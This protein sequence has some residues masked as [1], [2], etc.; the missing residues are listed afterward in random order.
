MVQ[1]NLSPHNNESPTRS[2]NHI[3]K[4]KDAI[5]GASHDMSSPLTVIK[6]YI[7]FFNMVEDEDKKLEILEKMAE[8]SQRLEMVISGLVELA[9]TCQFEKKDIHFLSLKQTVEKVMY[10]LI[11]NIDIDIKNTKI[12]TDFSEGDDIYYIK[13]L[14][15]K[16]IYQLLKNAIQYNI[17]EPQPVV[18]ISSKMEDNYLSL[19]IRDN[20][21][22][23]NLA[24]GRND[25]FKP[26]KRLTNIGKGRG[27]GL[28]L[29]K[30]IVERNG[31]SIDIE[32]QLGQG[33]LVKIRLTPYKTE[34]IISKKIR[35]I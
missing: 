5:H 23:I 30:N 22:G 13:P 20:G 9:D 26:F 3:F 14:L 34:G 18:S 11:Y 19:E 1:K 32:S 31:G 27:I 6:S 28:A 24:K 8:A 10:N 7:Q 2:I 33:T 15:E 35:L 25:L 29:V 4:L 17:D 21:P 16:V 12:E